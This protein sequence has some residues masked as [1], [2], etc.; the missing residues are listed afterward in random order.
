MMH[1]SSSGYGPGERKCDTLRAPPQQVISRACPAVNTEGTDLS[2]DE[3]DENEDD[4]QVGI[5]EETPNPAL[6]HRR[7]T[8]F[9]QV[10]TGSAADS[11]VQNVTAHEASP[12][13]GGANP[14]R[15]DSGSRSE[16]E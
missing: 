6:G 4:V 14:R 3:E 9:V 8:M 11:P 7:T 2:N 16:P 10:G 13:N 5:P 15:S 1:R 12:G